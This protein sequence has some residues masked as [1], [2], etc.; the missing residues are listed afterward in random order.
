[1]DRLKELDQKIRKEISMNDR[2]IKIIEALAI[3]MT[4]TFYSLWPIIRVL[5]YYLVVPDGRD[6]VIQF[7]ITDTLFYYILAQSVINSFGFDVVVYVLYRRFQTLNKLIVQL[8]ELSD[9]QWIAFKIRRIRE[10]HAGEFLRIL[11][12]PIM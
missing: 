3:F 8:D 5:Y 11:Y 7:M 2:S 1:M 6:P 10:M 9:V 4:I 12:N